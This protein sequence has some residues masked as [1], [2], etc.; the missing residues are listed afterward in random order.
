MMLWKKTAG[1]AATPGMPF[2]LPSKYCFWN[3]LHNE[4]AE[5]HL[6]FLNSIAR[7]KQLAPTVA[8]GDQ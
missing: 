1:N 5:P 4:C 6:H 3:K 2:L 7:V 8:L